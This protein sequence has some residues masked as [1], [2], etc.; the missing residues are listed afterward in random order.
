MFGVDVAS[1]AY[2]VFGCGVEV[3]VGEF[4]CCCAARL[5]GHLNAT[6]RVIPIAIIALEV[7]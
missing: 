2:E 6:Y 7:C 1:F 4:C 5:T 3:G